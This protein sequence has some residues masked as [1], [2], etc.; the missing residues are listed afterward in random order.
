VAGIEEGLQRIR[1]GRILNL[2][3]MSV[4]IEIML[5]QLYVCLFYYYYYYQAV[6]VTKRYI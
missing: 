3:N 5:L 6:S 1:G 2:Y 4:V